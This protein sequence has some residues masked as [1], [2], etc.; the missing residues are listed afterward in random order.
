MKTAGVLLAAGQGTRMKSSLPKVLHP[1]LGRPLISYG[2]ET[3]RAVT[4]VKP[5]VVIGYEAEKMRLALGDQVEFALQEPQLGTGHALQQTQAL[6]D[7]RVDQ[8]V[9]ITADMPLLTQASVSRVVELQAGNSGPISMLTVIADDPHGFGRIVRAAD[10]SVRAV[11]EEAQASPEQKQI[12]ELNASVYCFNAAWLWQSLPR[13]PLSPKGEYYL[14]DL[15]QIAVE[16]G[17]PVQAVA[18]QDAREAIGINTRVHL[19]EAGAILRQRV[20]EAWM[21]SGVTIIDPAT[22]YIEPGVQIGQDSVIWPNTYLQG[23]TRIGEECVI[24]PNSLLL[25]TWVGK[26]CK[27][28]ASILEKAELE[29]D[30]E[31][32]PFSHLRPAV[33]LGQGVHIGNFGEVKNS[34]LGTGVKMGHFSYIG[35]AMVG[36]QANIG[37]GTITCNFDGKKKNPTEIGAGAFIGSDTMLVAP[38]KVGEGAQTGAG[39]VVTKDIPADT[40]AVGVPARGIRKLK[41]GA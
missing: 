37:A 25:D 33:H 6:L 29:D 34:T 7:G 9:V 20:N 16:D 22:T 18:L 19:A 17:L 30:V 5:L 21:L 38:V 10:G 4:R 40:L 13:I 8:V 27:I 36:A 11:V 41:K 12:R 2:I 14:T 32:G 26:R 1:L 39:A 3:V 24:G 28:W 15:V 31:V 35:D 23:S